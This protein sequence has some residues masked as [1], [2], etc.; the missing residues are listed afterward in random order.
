[1]I[2]GYGAIGRRVGDVCRALRMRVEAVARRARPAE[3]VHGE[4]ALQALL[5]RADALILTL[6]ASDATRGIIGAAELARL[7]AH[8]LLVNVAR[9]PVID[10]DALYA[11][12]SEGRL[13]AAGL[14]VWYQ[15][16][17]SEDERE[18]TQP[19]RHP[20][21]ELDNIVLS[22]HRAGHCDRTPE[23]RAAH[24]AQLLNAAARG[25]EVPGLVDR[26]RGY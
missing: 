22:P 26:S 10:E 25:D 21:G 19:S 15:Y 6:P 4:E 3:D 14:D 1:M 2:V 24:V 11:A 23:L 20:F 18:S 12:A 8:A 7:P 17:A 16:P 9:G 5:P 13:G